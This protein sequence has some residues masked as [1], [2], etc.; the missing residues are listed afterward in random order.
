MKNMKFL[1]S[2][3]LIAFCSTLVLSG[4]PRGNLLFIDEFDGN[5]IDESKWNFVTGDGCGGSSGCG[6]GNNVIFN[7]ILKC[8]DNFIFSFLVY[9]GKT[10]LR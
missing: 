3:V 6:F 4:P 9:L 5:N 1:L 7:D 2:C 8:L 10:I